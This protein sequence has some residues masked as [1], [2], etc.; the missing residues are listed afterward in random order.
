MTFKEKYGDTA[1]VAGASEGIGA[2][3]MPMHQRREALIL[4]LLRAGYRPWKQLRGK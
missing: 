4:Y 3:Y 2:A 1:M